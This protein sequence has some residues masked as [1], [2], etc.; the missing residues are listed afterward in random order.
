[1]Q[2]R[3]RRRRGCRRCRLSAAQHSAAV[4]AAR[5]P[6]MRTCLG[7]SSFG[8]LGLFC[9]SPGLV[10]SRKCTTRSAGSLLAA[11]GS[12]PRRR[13]ARRCRAR[14]E[15]T[16]AARPGR[17]TFHQRG[18]RHLAGRRLE[19]RGA[20]I[21]ARALA[22]DCRRRWRMAAVAARCAH[23]QRK[24]PVPPGL[25]VRGRPRHSWSCVAGCAPDL[26]PQNTFTWLLPLTP[27]LH[28]RPF[29][30]SRLPPARAAPRLA[31][32]PSGNHGC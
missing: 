4:W 14:W 30:F 3:R 20:C 24:R 11:N 18:R 26:V 15:V 5:R 27:L 16:P 12:T 19:V 25:E 21:P 6:R 23:S 13:R 10:H 32:P 22:P 29:S 9:W 31:W 2:G 7:L 8:P 28:P 17:R 1:M